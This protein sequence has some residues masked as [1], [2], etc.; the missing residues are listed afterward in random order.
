MC[1]K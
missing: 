1:Y